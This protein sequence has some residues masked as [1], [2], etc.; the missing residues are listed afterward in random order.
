[1]KDRKPTLRT[2]YCH[3]SCFIDR[4]LAINRNQRGQI[5]AIQETHTTPLLVLIPTILLNY[6]ARPSLHQPDGSIRIS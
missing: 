4:V 2:S 1:M 3:V 6:D 5:Y